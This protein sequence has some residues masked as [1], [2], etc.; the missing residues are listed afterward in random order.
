[1]RNPDSDN[2]PGNDGITL[3]TPVLLA[4]DAT[5][6]AAEK[7]S[8]ERQQGELPSY[9]ILAQLARDDPEAYEAL[10]R[11][12]V[13]GFINSAPER[14]KPRL[15]GIQF[16]VDCMRRLSRTSTLGATVKVYRLMWKSFQHLNEVWQDFIQ[17]ENE[18]SKKPGTASA[19]KYSPENKAKILEFRPRLPCDQ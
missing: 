7:C 9:D 12:V 1:M 6:P 16:Q 17:I 18:G 19:A 5:E 15:N 14:L 10:R 2:K 13:E 11:E 3:V 4:S 8:V